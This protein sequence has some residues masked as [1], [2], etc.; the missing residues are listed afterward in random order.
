MSPTLIFSIACFVLISARRHF[1]LQ[2]TL[3]VAAD[4]VF[5]VLLSTR[6]AASPAAWAAAATTLAGAGL[7]SRGRM[8]LFFAAL[9]S[10]GVLLE[11]TYSM[12]KLDAPDTQYVQAG[13]LCGGVSSRSP[14]SRTRWPHTPWRASSSPRSARSTSPTWRRSTSS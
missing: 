11:Q 6:A 7:I 10:I 3:Q 12:L 5:I 1:N 8:T 14:G 4:V 9:A 2:L 13:L